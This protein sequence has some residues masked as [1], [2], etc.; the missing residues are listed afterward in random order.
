VPVPLDI[1]GGAAGKSQGRTS[2]PVTLVVVAMAG[3]MVETRWL[4][5]LVVVVLVHLM[6]GRTWRLES[7]VLGMADWQI[8]WENADYDA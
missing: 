2:V 3:V 4:V 6:A 5:T 8:P 7:L 1:A